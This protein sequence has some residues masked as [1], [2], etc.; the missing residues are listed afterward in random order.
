M[1]LLTIIGFLFLFGSAS[2]VDPIFP[3]LAISGGTVVAELRLADGGIEKINILSGGE[4]FVSSCKS[5]LAQWRLPSEKD[6]NA[7]VVV[8]FRH[9]NLYDYGNSEERI[10]CIKPKGS[11]P[12]PKSIIEPAYP[13]QIQAQGSVVLKTKISA[14]GSIADIRVL[15]ALGALT[16][17]GIDAVQKWE[18]TPAEDDR[19]MGKPSSAFVVLV[20]RFPVIMPGK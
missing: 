15:K 2:L 12:C 16:D 10:N 11:L 19:G 20:Y 3:P 4:P 9:Q 14:T 18:F 13:V 6:G 17:S 7:I 8:R 1:S 5:A